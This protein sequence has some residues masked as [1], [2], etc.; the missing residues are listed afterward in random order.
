MPRHL[1]IVSRETPHL[2]MRE[3]FRDE[4][5]VEVF[6]DRRAGDRT[7]P[8]SSLPAECGNTDRRKR[9]DADRAL[10]EAFHVFITVD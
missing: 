4:S 6:L 2:Y 9:H 3:Q 10:R 8:V 5:S 7:G 1:L